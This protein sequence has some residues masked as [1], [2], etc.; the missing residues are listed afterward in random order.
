[1]AGQLTIGRRV[2]D[3]IGNGFGADIV[4]MNLEKAIQQAT[5][6]AADP[7]S[8]FYDPLSLFMGQEWVDRK[9]GLSLLDLRA[10]ANN[11]IIASIIQT[12]KNQVAAFC[13]PQ[14]DDYSYGYVIKAKDSEVTGSKDSKVISDWIYGAGIPGYGEDL[15]ETLARKYI[16]DSLILDQACIEVVLRRDL[17][18]A[19]MVGIDAATI[20]RT[21]ASLD[22]ATP[23]NRT[24]PM[25]VQIINEVVQAQYT[26]DQMIFGIR[27]PKT[28]IRYVGYGMSELET[29]IRTVSTIVNAER[30]NSGQLTQGGI[31]K[32]VLIVKGDADR[33]QFESFKRDFREATRNAAAYWRPPVLQVSKDAEV[34]WVALDRSQKDMEYS[35]LFDFLVKQACGVYQI[36]PSEVN[37]SIAGSGTTTNFESGSDQKQMI[38]QWR[39][40]KPL[41]VHFANQI[42]IKVIDRID[43]RY[44]LE[45]E[46]LERDRLT[47]LD[48]R[49]KEVK[50]F[51]TL[52]EVRADINLPPVDGGDVVLNADYIKM[53]QGDSSGMG[54]ANTNW[55][56]GADETDDTDIESELNGAD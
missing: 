53:V 34:D 22:Y 54:D 49:I 46:G 12:R 37:W 39:G 31:A 28:D 15:F 13:Y 6:R 2:R 7:V 25:Y 14:K 43:P 50:N 40:L 29:L 32:G 24:E 27:N 21:K 20:R 45:F 9:T 3:M 18:P 19:Y 51:K 36:D 48:V 42:N 33:Q 35:Q 17:T 30:Y 4:E 41:L 56:M 5:D 1:M 16:E 47:D 8:Q 23:P 26:N 55:Q 38:S 52:N 44:R 10:M 11:P